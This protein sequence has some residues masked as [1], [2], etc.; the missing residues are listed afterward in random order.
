MAVFLALPSC[1]CQLFESLGMDFPHK[2]AVGKPTD[3]N[4]DYNGVSE[5]EAPSEGSDQELPVCHCEEGIGKT[6]EEC[7]EH[8]FDDPSQFASAIDQDDS[9]SFPTIS[10]KSASARA[11]PPK[12][13]ANYWLNSARTGVYR[14]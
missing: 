8:A 7:N 2:H 4:L 13:L 10:P 3:G 9:H 1:P 11:P 14:L 5:W 12:M 6:A